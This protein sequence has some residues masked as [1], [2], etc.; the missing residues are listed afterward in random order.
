MGPITYNSQYIG[1]IYLVGVKFGLVIL[2]FISFPL[3]LPFL[4]SIIIFQHQTINKYH[5]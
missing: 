2:C 3:N 5:F 1:I 4:S